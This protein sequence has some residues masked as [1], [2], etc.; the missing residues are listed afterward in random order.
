MI[1]AAVAGLAPGSLGPFGNWSA[2]I[3][4]AYFCQQWPSPAGN[5]TLA[6]GPFP[7]VPVLALNGGIDLRTPTVNALAVVSQFPQGRL[8]EVPGVGHSVTGAD[9]S[10]CSQNAVRAWILGT[11]VAP[12]LASCPRV[13][14]IVKVLTTFPRAPSRPSV[15]TTVA[16]AAKALREAEAAWWQLNPPASTMRGLFGGKLVQLPKGDGFTLTKYAL[17]P[18]VF[19]TGKIEF[20]GIGPPSTYKGTIRISG[21]AAVGGTL[22]ISKNSLSGRLGGRSVK[23]KY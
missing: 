15:Q 17:T 2:R 11:L 16:V 9:V 23:S 20:V 19:I 22:K 18:G 10:G 7:N 4:R 6:P 14:P 5:G 1:A 12:T 13:L 8:I 21:P 3:G